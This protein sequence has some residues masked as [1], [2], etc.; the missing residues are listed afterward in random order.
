MPKP[1]QPIPPI[2]HGEAIL[3]GTPT[4]DKPRAEILAQI[5][6]G[7]LEYLDVKATVF[8]T[9]PNKNYVQF[10]EEELSSFASS[11]KEQPFLRNHNT[12]DIAA[13]DGIIHDSELQGQQFIQTLRITTRDG[14]KDYVEGRIDRF[15][16]G[17]H[18][19]DII[20]TICNT[21]WM[22]C[23]H[24]PGRT[25]ETPQGKKTCY[26]LFLEPK[27]KE[28]SAVNNPAVDG[29]GLLHELE[30]FKLEIT[31]ETSPALIQKQNSKG[32][33]MPK[34]KTTDDEVTE[35]TTSPSPI[36]Q[37]IE[38]NRLASAR[39]SGETER[40]ADLNAQKERSDQILI[41]QL[42]QLLSTALNGSGLP[43]VTRKRLDKQ[44]KGTLFE[45]IEL[46]TAILEAKQ[47]V[48][49]L[50]SGDMIQSGGSRITGMYNSNDQVQAAVDDMFKVE[51]DND[52]VNLKVQKLHGIRELYTMLTGDWGFEGG[53]DMG[54]Y[55]RLASSFP[56]VIKN[57]MNKR[58]VKAWARY[59]EA[60]YNWWEKVTTVEHF[61]NLEDVDWI[62]LGTIGTL[63]VV[64]KGA[65][66]TELPTGDNGETSVWYK[67]G[68][69]VG[70]Y[71]EDIINDNL[72][73]FLAMPD[74]VAM[75]GI[76]NI[77]EQIANI[78]INNPTLSDGG[79]LFNATA[80]TTAG[81]HLNLL[82]TALGT[83]YDAW[84]AQAAAMYNH[85]MHIANET[86]Q[87]G[88]GKKQAIDPKF[89]MGP[90]ALRG[91]ANNLF[92]QRQPSVTTNSDWYGTV[93][94]L[95][96]P[97]LT[98]ANDWYGAADPTILPGLML[99]EIFGVMPQI[100]VAGGE[101]NP[102]MFTND[103]SRIKVRQFNTVGVSNWR[104]LFKNVVT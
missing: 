16:I 38:A 49:Q 98:D 86:G 63:P 47:E 10:K 28:T 93:Q 12:Y 97:E 53:I 31:R 94:P 81:G 25:Y 43:E 101:Q 71:L 9:K 20:C 35:E 32:V 75:G 102:A 5:E 92:I 40:L 65:E 14:M 88:A 23:P 96:V 18:Y 42:E 83:N 1:K 41:A 29:T 59:G 79:A 72:R 61:N 50:T 33:H 58:M 85:T 15:S 62:I 67:Y 99:G 48:Q 13:R 100:F 45:P 52:K 7:E 66:Y 6:S 74:N 60:G 70:I 37:Q 21:S 2:L 17:W 22:G 84:E 64:A 80:E 30:S 68:G 89:W 44:F 34:P 82:T 36:E 27:G 4:L 19:K 11:F 57:A 51:R 87:Y 56:V 77:S 26:L 24:Y 3:A 104:A 78:L 8:N 69:Y 95:T 91:Q 46:E 39:L 90:R 73:A 103:E 54:I 55:S 76:R